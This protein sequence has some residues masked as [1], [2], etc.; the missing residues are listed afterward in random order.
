M[1]YRPNIS[2]L[3]SVKSILDECDLSYVWTDQYFVSATWLCNTV[4][5]SLIDQWKHIWH[6]NLQNSPKALNYR[7]FKEKWELEKYF[8]KLSDIN[9][10]TLCRF[11]TTKHKL[12]IE[13]GM[14]QNIAKENRK[15]FIYLFI[16]LVIYVSFSCLLCK[17]VLQSSSVLLYVHF[18]LVC[19]FLYNIVS[20]IM[21]IKIYVSKL[22]SKYVHATTWLKYC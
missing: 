1:N 16:Y 22:I 2:W 21:K 18:V 13:M 19:V 4:E 5:Q 8:K 20:W 15:C 17:F 12:P 3:K 10:I 14:W 6:S 7:I 9:I 11:R